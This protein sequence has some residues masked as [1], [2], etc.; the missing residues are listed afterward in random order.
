VI[1]LQGLATKA[2][3]K[4]RVVAVEEEGAAEDEGE[5]EAAEVVEE[6]VRVFLVLQMTRA[7]RFHGRGRK[8]TRVRVRIIIARHSEGRRWRELVSQQHSSS[9]KCDSIP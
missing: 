3:E 1:A 6:A 8:P 4:D 7:R 5:E 9:L 2:V